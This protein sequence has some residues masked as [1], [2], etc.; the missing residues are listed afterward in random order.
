MKLSVVNFTLA[1]AGVRGCVIATIISSLTLMP[2]ASAAEWSEIEERGKII[3]GVKDNL[4]P[5]GFRDRENK[6]L[7]LEIELARKLAT[8]LLGDAEAVEFLPVTNEERLQLVLDE[9]VDIAIA[10]VGVTTPRARIVN[11]SSYYYLDGTGLITKNTDIKEL[12]S[13]KQA[14]IAVLENSA[15]IAVVRNRLP[16]AE[17]VGVDS[18]QAALQLLATGEVEAFAGDRTVLTGLIQEYPEY[19][20]LPTRLSGV[21]LAIAMPKGLQ[22]QELRRKIQKAIAKLKTSGWLEARIEYWGL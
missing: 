17:L 22:Y 3:V 10:Q 1:I 13:L 19:K 5:L 2:L 9:Q 8:E 21:P 20:L 14:K 4:R 18:Y 16:D 7:G 15:T 11:F 12:N 6:L